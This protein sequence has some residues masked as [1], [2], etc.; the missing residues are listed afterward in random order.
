MGDVNEQLIVD[1]PSQDEKFMEWIWQRIHVGNCLT[2]V[3]I[4]D[5]NDPDTVVGM[6]VVALSGQGLIPVSGTSLMWENSV[7]KERLEQAFGDLGLSGSS[8]D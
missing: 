5:N 8:E 6:S 2:I 4:Y 7:Y 3:P 1:L